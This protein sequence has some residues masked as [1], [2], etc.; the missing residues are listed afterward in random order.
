M[1]IATLLIAGCS[2]NSENG[3]S[4]LNSEPLDLSGSWEQT[5]S[6][7]MSSYQAAYISSE[8]RIEVYWVGEDAS[9]MLYWSGTYEAPNES[10]ETYSWTSENDIT[11]TGSAL[12]ASDAE[13]KDFYYENGKLT[14][15]VKAFGVTST[16]ELERTDNDYSTFG[17]N[18]EA[19]SQSELQEVQLVN[20]GYSISTNNGRVYVGYAVDIKNP[21]ESYAI[22]YPAIQITAKSSDGKIL[23]TEE[24]TLNSIAAGDEYKYGNSISYEGEE[25]AIVEIGVSNADNSYNYEAQS[26]SDIGYS[27]DFVVSNVSEISGDYPTFTGELTNNSVNDS[28]M[29]A[30]IVIYKSDD[31][32][33]GGAVTY[34]DDVKS[35]ETKVFELE[36][37][38][39][40]IQGYDSYELYAINW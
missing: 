6:G 31:Q 3:N 9:P 20:S 28:S 35:G 37:I 17:P 38:F 13:T 8:G 40:H 5:G 36:D 29:V 16:V 18:T 10:E 34:I 12:M 39:S 11:R 19:A 22:R 15:E 14:Y 21:N 24:M 30:L 25:P 7:D 23:T 1:A 2:S 32:L 4:S 26:S 33:I 27:T